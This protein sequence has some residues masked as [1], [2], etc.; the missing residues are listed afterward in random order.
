[1]GMGRDGTA[2]SHGPWPAWGEYGGP[3][4]KH[5]VALAHADRTESLG[6]PRP[7]QAARPGEVVPL[8]ALAKL[9]S[10]L[11]LSAAG[12]PS[13]VYRL[14]PAHPRASG[15]SWLFD[16]RP[17]GGEDGGPLSVER[18]LSAATPPPPP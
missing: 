7:D 16:L 18:L 12:E 3:H 2:T 5:A 4:C 15:R 8:P 14:A 11:G 9:E 17:R 1:V 6:P 10:W 13:F